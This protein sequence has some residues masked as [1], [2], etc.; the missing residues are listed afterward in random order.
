MTEEPLRLR[1]GGGVQAVAGAPGPTWRQS[2]LDKA[3][4]EL[5]KRIAESGELEGCRMTFA[6]AA[7]PTSGRIWS[8]RVTSRKMTRKER[9]LK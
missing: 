4:A 5:V 8:V 9:G 6:P 3:A 2:D 7:F 1:T